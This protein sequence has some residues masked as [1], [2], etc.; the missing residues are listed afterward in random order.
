MHRRYRLWLLS[1]RVKGVLHCYRVTG[2]S[3]RRLAL[4]SFPAKLTLQRYTTHAFAA[5]PELQLVVSKMRSYGQVGF[6]EVGECRILLKTCFSPPTKLS[7]CR[8]HL[9]R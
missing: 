2:N 7:H 8:T 3:R 5:T 4:E 9:N 1:N 6:V